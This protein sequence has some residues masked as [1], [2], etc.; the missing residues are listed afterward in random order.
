MWIANID[1]IRR[2]WLRPGKTYTVGRSSKND[3]DIV[4]NEPSV[5]RSHITISIAATQ[6]A[7]AGQV[8]IKSRV[9]VT[10]LGSR[11]GSQLDSAT[12]DPNSPKMLSTGSDIATLVL[13]TRSKIVLE[14]IPQTI[15]FSAGENEN[16]E[17]EKVISLLEPLDIK[18]VSDIVPSTKFFMKAAKTST[19]LVYALAKGLPVV[20]PNFAQA[21]ADS[22]DDI[23]L[24]FAKF[25]NALQFLADPKFAP[26]EA[27]KTCLEDRIFY[28][29]DKGQ[30]DALKPIIVQAGGQCVFRSEPWKEGM[31]V[32]DP[33]DDELKTKAEKLG[34]VVEPSAFLVAVRD[35]TSIRVVGSKARRPK[36]GVDMLTFMTQSQP[37]QMSQPSKRNEPTQMSEDPKPSQKRKRVESV[38]NVLFGPQA[39]AA[40]AAEPPMESQE[41]SSAHPVEHVSVTDHNPSES[42]PLPDHKPS[43]N[44]RKRKIS[45]SPTPSKLPARSIDVDTEDYNE[46]P[47][48]M[49]S[50]PEL[51]NL[52]LVESCIAV[53]ELPQGPD[54][55][56]SQAW[57][58]VPNFKAFKRNSPIKTGSIALVEAENVEVGN[59]VLDD[60]SLLDEN[61]EP[62]NVDL[63]DDEFSFHFS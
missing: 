20:T 34:N 2:K 40:K 47:L 52:V 43:D 62:D 23:E 8:S 24:D 56:P 5:S 13:G 19:K 61:H 21:I 3:R 10:D 35:K 45:H 29:L 63:D 44:P 25:P 6:P 39:K 51:A 32:V 28:I 17:L 14:W 57:A 22:V 37:T 38:A 18:I 42:K 26:D 48:S 27:R 46:E 33:P 12:L 41:P 55:T 11:F 31:L 50:T 1:G 9:T 49:P 4:I 59:N 60:E 30:Y 15:T 16:S 7:S 53:D 58:N 54:V 36:R